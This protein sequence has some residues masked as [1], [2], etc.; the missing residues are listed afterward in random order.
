MRKNYFVYTALLAIGFV[1]PIQASVLKINTNA[2]GKQATSFLETLDGRTE[3][4]VRAL[5]RG[6]QIDFEALQLVVLLNQTANLEN[7]LDKLISNQQKTNAL[8]AKLIAASTTSPLKT[9]P[10]S[11]G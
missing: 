10:A 11:K 1:S 4:F 6:S 8:L 3:G 5:R 7:K 2:T 9:T